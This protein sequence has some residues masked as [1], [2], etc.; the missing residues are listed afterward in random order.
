MNTTQID[1]DLL[2]PAMDAGDGCVQILTDRLAATRGVEMAHITQENGT[3]CLCLHFDPNLV[4]LQKIQRLARR[5]GAEITD[6]YRHETLPLL[7]M[8]A[9]DAATGLTEVLAGLPGMLHAQVNY[10]AGLAFVAYDS[11]LL[12][13]SDIAAA[14]HRMGYG[15][16]GRAEGTR[17]A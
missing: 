9:A 1:L 16:G 12:T 5:A 17:G 10:A 11:Q 13:A 3:A 14:I 4:S 2:L 15:V 8:D 6:R 7:G